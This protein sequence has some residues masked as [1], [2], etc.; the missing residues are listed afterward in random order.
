ML[1]I[2]HLFEMGMEFVSSVHS[3]RQCFISK[4]PPFPE[5]SA[6]L[7]YNPVTNPFKNKNYKFC[8]RK[9]SW[10]YIDMFIKNVCVRIFTDTGKRV[11][12]ISSPPFFFNLRISLSH[13]LSSGPNP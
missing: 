11:Q 8:L 5:L 2:N 7:Q 10:I 6:C 3:A 1:K 4:A 13:Q 9:S 12:V